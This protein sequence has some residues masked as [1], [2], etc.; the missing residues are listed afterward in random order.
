MVVDVSQISYSWWNN[1]PDWEMYCYYRINESEWR[2]VEI[3]DKSQPPIG[4]KL[5]GTSV[6]ATYENEQFHFHFDQD[7]REVQ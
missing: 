6:V 2:Y 1:K 3:F 7:V 4:L 5:P